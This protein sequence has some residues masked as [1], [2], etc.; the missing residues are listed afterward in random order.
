MDSPSP[1]NTDEATT[2]DF[3][4][5]EDRIFRCEVVNEDSSIWPVRLRPWQNTA[6]DYIKRNIGANRTK[7]GYFLYIEGSTILRDEVGYGNIQDFQNLLESAVELFAIE[8]NTDCESS[9]YYEKLYEIEIND[10]STVGGSVGEPN[11]IRVPDSVFS[12]VK[13]TYEVDARFEGWIHRA[14]ISMGLQRSGV[15]PQSMIQKSE[16]CCENTNQAYSDARDEVEGVI[17][18][19]VAANRNYW[20]ENGILQKQYDKIKEV[21]DLMATGRKHIVLQVAEEIGVRGDK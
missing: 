18:D 10:P 9:K 19:F 13:D 8:E 21:I 20:Y 17:V 3:D 14:V 15:L 1:F 6:L 4:S 5:L 7:V 2:G 12:E 16:Q 11:N